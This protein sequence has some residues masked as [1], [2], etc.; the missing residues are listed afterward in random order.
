[1]VINK[2]SVLR[3]RS[4]QQPVIDTNA[5]QCHHRHHLSRSRYFNIVVTRNSRLDCHRYDLHA[6]LHLIFRSSLAACLLL[7]RFRHA[8]AL[9]HKFNS[10]ARLLFHSSR[11][12]ASHR[13]LRI[14]HLEDTQLPRPRHIAMY[15]RRTAPHDDQHHQECNHQNDLSNS[16]NHS[17]SNG[18]SIKFSAAKIAKISHPTK[19][20]ALKILN[21]PI[22]PSSPYANNSWPSPFCLRRGRSWP[23]LCL[24]QQ[25]YMAASPLPPL[26]PSRSLPSP[27]LRIAIV[28]S[29]FHGDFL[30]SICK[31]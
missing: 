10:T 31:I 5:Q 16:L 6:A 18:L 7:H 21:P 2:V 28:Y 29:S 19:F 23:P 22:F 1:M 13:R 24:R 30:M 14:Q 12:A 11:H 27:P 15:Q 25:L 20:F 17:N 4:L 9:F 3:L 8:A 26:S